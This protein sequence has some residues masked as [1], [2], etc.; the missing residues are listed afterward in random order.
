MRLIVVGDVERGYY[1]WFRKKMDKLTSRLREQ[2]KKFTIA[3][4]A[5]WQRNH[6]IPGIHNLVD[7]W[8]FERKVTLMVHHS[9][10]AEAAKRDAAMLHSTTDKSLLL[11]FGKAP[12]GLTKLARKLKIK[13]RTIGS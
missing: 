9:P 3:V 7:K 2:R 12:K 10:L 8:A 4:A 6:I 5:N 1:H 13:V 11:V